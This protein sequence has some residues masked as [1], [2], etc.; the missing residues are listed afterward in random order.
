MEQGRPRASGGR[1]LAGWVRVVLYRY[2]AVRVVLAA[3]AG[4]VAF[5]FVNSLEPPNADVTATQSTALAEGVPAAQRLPA[6]TR[7][8]SVASQSDALSPGDLVDLHEL[9]TS[10][11]VVQ[12]ALVVEVTQTETIVAV[13]AHLVHQ[14]VDALTQGGLTMTLVPT[15]PPTQ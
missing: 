2:R 10:A 13:P 7:G 3:L 8:V 11:L 4:V 9:R 1:I 12:S 6:N 14:V 5:S 15:P